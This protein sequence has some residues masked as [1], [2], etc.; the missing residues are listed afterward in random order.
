MITL[1]W[2]IINRTFCIRDFSSIFNQ[3]KNYQVS[4]EVCRL[5]MIVNEHPESTLHVH[6]IC[7]WHRLT[8]VTSQAW[9]VYFWQ[10]FLNTARK[11]ETR[12]WIFIFK[13]KAWVE[14]RYKRFWLRRKIKLDRN[15]KNLQ[16]VQ[17]LTIS[18]YINI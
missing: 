7:F 1:S 12:V 5:Y 3:F 6:C 8:L 17:S 2:I 10:N 16:T 9:R 18:P 14:V 15:E 4:P 13:N 11:F